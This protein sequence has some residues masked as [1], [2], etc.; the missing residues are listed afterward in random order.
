MSCKSQVLLEHCVGQVRQ[1]LNKNVSLAGHVRHTCLAP[2][3]GCFVLLCA[4]GPAAQ[5]SIQTELWPLLGFRE[6]V[7]PN[8]I[9]KKTQKHVLLFSSGGFK[10]EQKYVV[11]LTSSCG[12][13]ASLSG[14]TAVYP[15]LNRRIYTYTLKCFFSFSIAA[16]C[17]SFIV[18]NNTKY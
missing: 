2:V 9:K 7:H 8:N 4:A 3:K 17:L 13:S 16:G 15:L 6:P 10:P 14:M 11:P 5:M 1:Q 18:Q 12:A